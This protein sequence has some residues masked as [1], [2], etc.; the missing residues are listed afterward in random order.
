MM[1]PPQNPAGEFVSEEPYGAK[2]RAEFIAV[3]AEAPA[4]LRKL[5]AP[6]R[7]E[8]LDVHYRNW[9]IRQIVHHLADSHVNSYIRFKWALT[10]E[11]PTIKAYDETRWA[12][13][14][15]SRTGDISAPLGLLEGLHAQW[16]QLLRLMIDADFAR[17]FLHPETGKTVRLD[18]ALCYY[19]WHCKHHTAQIAWLCQERGWV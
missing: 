18:A 9:T 15:D 19:A 12:D 6:L 16:V 11:Q 14:A 7:D 5:V 10:E 1:Q 17:S 2:R 13:L 8:Q 4:R 3:I